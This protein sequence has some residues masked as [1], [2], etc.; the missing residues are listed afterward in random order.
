M[1]KKGDQ[2]LSINKQCQLLGIHRSGF[3]Y[4]PV[5]ESSLNEYLMGRIDE[6]FLMHPYK[7]TRRMTEWLKEQ[8]YDVNRKRVQNLYE[9]MGLETIYPGRI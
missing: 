4:E 8:G 5:G 3:Y 7:G 2:E 6:H 9:K 1:V